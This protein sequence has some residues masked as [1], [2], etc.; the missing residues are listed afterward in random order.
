M[1][2]RRHSR[3]AARRRAPARQLS[4]GNSFYRRALSYEPLEDR[5]LLAVVT[6][7]TLADTV[8]FNDGHTSLREAIFATNTV[9][10]ADTINFAPSLTANGPAT[11]TLTQG[12]LKITDALTIIGPGANLLTIDA[13]GNDP[14]PNVDNGDGSRIFNIDDSNRTNLLD[15]GIT[16]LSLTGGDVPKAGAGGGAIF[17]Y[18][19]L[20]ISHV[21]I[22]DSAASN[23]G[24]IACRG[25]FL[26]IQDSN[27]SGNRA[28]R[29][30]AIYTPSV[31][32]I[33]RS[34]ISGNVSNG[35]G[36]AGGGGIYCSN[37]ADIEQ[38]N[39]SN[40]SSATGGG[41]ILAK[42]NLTLSDTVVD[43]NK[44]GGD[45]F[46][47][48]GGILNAAQRSATILNCTIT[49]NTSA[50]EG[51]GIRRE[52]GSLTIDNS[53]I[54]GNVASDGAGISAAD[55]VTAQITHSTIANNT[56]TPILPRSGV[57]TPA[58]FGFGGGVFIIN[59]TFSVVDCDILGNIAGE[60][61]GVYTRNETATIDQCFIHGNSAPTGGG[62]FSDNGPGQLT[63][64]EST[65]AQNS[66]QAGGGIA[67][68]RSSVQ[69]TNSTISDNTATAGGGINNNQGQLSL[70]FST[71][72]ANQ[73]QPGQGAGI[74]G[75][76]S[77]SSLSKVSESIVAGNIGTDVDLV[78]T[79]A[80]N[81][82]QS[83]GY[84]VIGSGN[85]TVS[86]YQPGDQVGVTNPL[87]GALADNGGFTL[88]GGNH[89]LTHALLAG[90]LAINAGDL[91]AIAGVNGVPQYD[92][93]GTPYSRVFGGRIDIGAFE[94]QQPSDLNLVVDTLVDE[95][96]G[97]FGHGDLSLR[98][99]IQLANMYSGPNYPGVVQT[100]HF[101]PALTTSGPAT[102]LLT[103]GE[104][105]ITGSMEIDGP[106]AD[107]LTIDASGNDPTPG[108]V[109]HKGSRIFNVSD[110]MPTFTTVTIQNLTL[111]GGDPSGAGGAITSAEDLRLKNLNVQQNSA[112]YSVIQSSGKLTIDGN[113]IVD[114]KTISS[115]PDGS[116]IYAT[117]L[118]VMNSE[119]TGNTVGGV[120]ADGD[121]LIVNTTISNNSGRAIWSKGT[122]NVD[123]EQCNISGNVA[124][125]AAI[126]LR[127]F[128]GNVLINDS[129]ISGNDSLQGGGGI[130]C[131]AIR[132][133]LTVSDCTISDNH[134]ASGGGMK[135]AG[136]V[137]VMDCN[138]NSNYAGAL[139]ISQP[140]IPTNVTIT[141]TT[142]RENRAY[143]G[144][145]IF[146]TGSMI[147]PM[148]IEDC[149]FIANTATGTNGGAIFVQFPASCT[150]TN[151][152]FHA[153]YAQSSGGA[154]W[155]DGS[156]ISIMNSTFD[157]NSAGSRGGA[158]A[159]NVIQGS[160]VTIE[161]STFSD[162]WSNG[163]G[164]AI[165]VI[166]NGG[167]TK[168]ASTTISNNGFGGNGSAV[169]AS[170]TGVFAITNSIVAANY[171]IT[172]PDLL[173]TIPNS[174]I[175]YSLIGNGSGSGL[176]SAPI[177]SPD[178][179]GNLV[180][181]TTSSSIINPL[182][183]PLANNGGTTLTRA[184]L[185]GSPALNSGDPTAAPGQNGVPTSD[186]RGA[187]FIRIYGGRI[188]IGAIESQPNDLP[189]DF[190]HNGVVDMAD[191][192]VWRAA[193]T[194]FD[195]RADANGDGRVDDA[196]LAVWRANFGQTYASSGAAATVAV[197][198]ARARFVAPAPTADA[199]VSDSTAKHGGVAVS[200]GI[201]VVEALLNGSG[202]AR[203]EIAAKAAQPL[204]ELLALTTGDRDGM[205][206]T[207][208]SSVRRRP[209]IDDWSRD[210]SNNDASAFDEALATFGASRAS[211]R[212]R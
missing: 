174:T 121:L 92:E 90:S 133:E 140:V 91:N 8:D 178:A 179:N 35:G 147:G 175:R 98:E 42:G 129:T 51:G 38:S 205:S 111:T 107:L 93:R 127:T 193:H 123:I 135:V 6:V 43:G 16:G 190:D 113:H 187:P 159:I 117:A 157:S 66:G 120:I 62:I 131:Y 57:G 167:A 208:S 48:G 94:Y 153:N 177:G 182:L 58:Y 201:P 30:G 19:N 149:T 180:G 197:I 203:R 59:G 145:A 112:E 77:A 69:A 97:N 192:V 1:S 89:I 108:V 102:I 33:V 144:A 85:A 169:Y 164:N 130:D 52:F 73:A 65:V 110:N 109:D 212:S 86:F 137:N 22:S 60:G 104:L 41:G 168:I 71:I 106:G 139:L 2:K 14:T 156:P 128:D 126:W 122:G 141:G 47:G 151:S 78:G 24:G 95:S 83:L 194:T 36:S 115:K 185:P 189:G 21:T 196:D 125:L 124:D 200:L 150:V 12:E 96:D 210:A 207:N 119:I 5:R 7:D 87:L 118:T 171:G 54:S 72:T 162:N 63:L 202:V 161:Q 45:G 70:Q 49:N 206:P 105:K 172:S 13:S 181:G 211:I 143:D 148:S 82:L 15:I 165:S 25:G 80:M 9:P 20:T 3:P 99:A 31:L 68:Y 67:I 10:G 195:P 154:V 103:T 84:N 81:S 76:M 170:G 160:T 32:T 142:F 163:N 183:G 74:V 56:T 132:G 18:E 186:Q 158:V 23:G 88:P 29:G 116:A 79:G 11:I 204:L 40:N 50:S 55:S 44:S 75:D 152:T 155:S 114:N 188:D 39:I 34:T 184:L 138:F 176:A 64:I 209:D 46:N 173:T 199:A 101:D 53:M 166:A 37:D 146:A 136:I 26:T 27:I 198:P 28:L 61:G 4:A 191:Y 134:A 17:S 100:I